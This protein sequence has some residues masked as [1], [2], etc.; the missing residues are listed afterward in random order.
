MSESRMR[1]FSSDEW[2]LVALALSKLPGIGRR[3]LRRA[4]AMLRQ[5]TLDSEDRGSEQLDEVLRL[6]ALPAIAPS[7]RDQAW[8]AALR[9][10]DRCWQQNWHVYVFG[11]ARYPSPLLRSSDPPALLFGEGVPITVAVPRVAIVGT[12]QPTEWGRETAAACARL[13]AERGAVV[14]SGLAVGIDAE[15]HAAVVA[16]HGTTWATLPC[17]LDRLYPPEHRDLAAQIV[18]AGGTLISEYWPGSGARRD[19]F[20]ERDR[21]QVGLSGLL[22][23]VEAGRRGGTQHTIGFAPAADVPIWV[24]LPDA[25]VA[26]SPAPVQLGTF[27]LWRGGSPRVTAAALEAWIVEARSSLSTTDGAHATTSLF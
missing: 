6:A 3:R 10:Q 17:G 11:G 14:V 13:C 22:L 15:A 27:D 21:L 9:M 12:R 26:G 23:V 24:A 1:A 25:A 7:A 16:A 2:T 20:I 18:D 5:S 4:L 8:D 19:R